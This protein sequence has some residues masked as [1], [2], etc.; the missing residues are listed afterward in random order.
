M[1]KRPIAA[2]GV[3]ESS[4]VGVLAKKNGNNKYQQKGR[5]WRVG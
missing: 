2:G 5:I 3:K 1:P 4:V